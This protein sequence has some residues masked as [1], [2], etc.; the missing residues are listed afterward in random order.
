MLKILLAL[1][2]LSHTIPGNVSLNG[3]YWR[4]LSDLRHSWNPGAPVSKIV[5][6]IYFDRA[7]T[8]AA[9]G[10]HQ[11][12]VDLL[13]S[14]L[15]HVRHLPELDER[16]VKTID[17][18]AAQSK[19]RGEDVEA[20]QIVA[21]MQMQRFHG[22]KHVYPGAP[23]PS[24]SGHLAVE[25]KIREADFLVGE[26]DQPKSERLYR[27][28]LKDVLARPGGNELITVKLVDRLCR[29]YYR[30][31]RYK[32]GEE[33]VLKQLKRH[34]SMYEH[35]DPMDP[36]KLHVAFLL[37]DLGLLDCGMDR[38]YEAEALYD[39]ALP[40]MALHTKE[41]AADYIVTLGALARV[42]KFMGRLDQAERD[43]R[44]ALYM[45]EKD[46]GI[47]RLSVGTIMNNYADLLEKMG[48]GSRAQKM[49]ERAR[50][51]MGNAAPPDQ[52]SGK[53]TGS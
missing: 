3:S 38:L 13:E 27:S 18:L 19:A 34:E 4:H 45:A 49:R 40:V 32:E 16:R 52:V 17:L 25:A 9:R 35:M 2:V 23:G 42:H 1:T 20:P 51:F 11:G 46:E 36:E 7:E 6:K 48:K 22:E 39:A 30:Q 28:A 12:A 43:Y 33:L 41:N 8:L 31:G 15:E 14:A 10:D 37:S 44:K 24:K 50:K 21:F 29:L 47:S 53:K 26:G 5:W